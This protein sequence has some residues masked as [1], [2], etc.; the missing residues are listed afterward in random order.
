LTRWMISPLLST[1]SR[2]PLSLEFS[3]ESSST[4][5]SGTAPVTRIT[6]T[7]RRPATWVEEPQHLGVKRYPGRRDRNAA[8]SS[9]V[10]SYTALP[11][12]LQQWETHSARVSPSHH[13]PLQPFCLLWAKSAPFTTC[14]LELSPLVSILLKVSLGRTE[15]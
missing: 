5:R 9:P 11:G 6:S 1:T 8:S 15:R 7:W 4:M 12:H 3:E 10:S 13:D 2:L 14:L